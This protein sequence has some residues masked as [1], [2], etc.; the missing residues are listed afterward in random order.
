[1]KIYPTSAAT[2]YTIDTITNDTEAHTVEDMTTFTGQTYQLGCTN[3]LEA[4]AGPRFC[5]IGGTLVIPGSYA[6]F[7]MD[8]SELKVLDRH[9]HA[10]DIIAF[11]GRPVAVG[12][13]EDTTPGGTKLV[14]PTRGNMTD[15]D[16]YGAGE[17]DLL[18]DCSELNAA[19]KWGQEG[20]VFSDVG[21]HYLIETGLS[22][23]NPIAAKPV[24]VHDYLPPTSNIVAG[25]KGLYYWTRQGPVR[26][27]NGRIEPLW[28]RLG[29]EID[30]IAYNLTPSVHYCPYLR[31]IT[32]SDSSSLSDFRL[33]FFE[34]IDGFG[35]VSSEY[36]SFGIEIFNIRYYI[37]LSKTL[38]SAS[39]VYAREVDKDGTVG[40]HGGTLEAEVGWKGI[41]G[42][43][44]PTI[45][46]VVQQL[47]VSYEGSGTLSYKVIP[48][49]GSA[50]YKT[51][52]LSSSNFA[53]EVIDAP[54]AYEEAV[55]ELWIK[56]PY[57][58]IIHEIEIA[59]TV[60]GD[61]E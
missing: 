20:F 19:G 17:L 28:Q 51:V 43:E 39:T 31:A 9:W 22:A 53:T 1:M 40:P 54:Y 8:S 24:P 58:L 25:A 61:V 50:S 16:S 11:A 38:G 60:S 56:I 30:Y 27:M 4:T 37:A 36:D 32:F 14:W 52:A 49:G 47:R 10:K 29:Y 12:A 42:Q 6:V 3:L 48:Q 2:W 5:W 15:W 7:Y 55:F 59:Y 46:K 26:F 21:I 18:D 45:S 44:G 35:E 13:K 23:A 34:D 33:N 41:V 57:T